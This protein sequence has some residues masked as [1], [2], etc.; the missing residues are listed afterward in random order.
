MIE[1]VTIGLT[2]VNGVPRRVVIEP[3]ESGRIMFRV[4]RL[5][6]NGWHTVAHAAS[7]KVPVDNVEGSV[8]NY[9]NGST[10]REYDENESVGYGGTD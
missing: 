6:G 5:E 7:T 2:P 9:G 10:H 4:Q 1:S 3:E 8:G